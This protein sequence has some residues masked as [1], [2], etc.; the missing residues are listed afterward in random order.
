MVK[1]LTGIYVHV[2]QTQCNNIV[3]KRK[4]RK[5]RGREKTKSEFKEFHPTYALDLSRLTSPKPNSRQENSNYECMNNKRP[6][7]QTVLE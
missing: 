4:K 7:L 6:V 1:S 2:L 3:L 5:K